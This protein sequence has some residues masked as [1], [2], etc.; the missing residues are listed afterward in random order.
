MGYPCR[1]PQAWTAR[2]CVAGSKVTVGLTSGAR[3]GRWRRSAEEREQWWIRWR[4]G[5]VNSGGLGDGGRG[6]ADQAGSRRLRTR[7]RDES[8]QSH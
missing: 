1:Y 6:L 7:T 8:C 3:G 2:V 5:D 4:I